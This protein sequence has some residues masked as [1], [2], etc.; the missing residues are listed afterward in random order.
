VTVPYVGDMGQK[1]KPQLT[2]CVN[3]KP[4]QHS[5]IPI[6]VLFYW[7]LRKLEV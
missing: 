6:W 5:D 7:N 4:G 1:R 2:F 3:V